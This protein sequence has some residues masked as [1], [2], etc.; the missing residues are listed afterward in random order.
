MSNSIEKTTATMQRMKRGIDD[1][2]ETMRLSH[3]QDQL[4][5]VLQAE[6]NGLGRVVVLGDS[7]GVILAQ[8]DETI[9]HALTHSYRDF[10]K[11]VS[12]AFGM[13]EF[14]PEED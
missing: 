9:D 5:P 12:E 13:S 3:Y 10:L 7:S 1:A 6:V 4:E 8:D 14:H 11:V 2:V